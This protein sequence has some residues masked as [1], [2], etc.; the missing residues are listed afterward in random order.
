MIWGKQCKKIDNPIVSHNRLVRAAKQPINVLFP[1]R[2]DL[3]SN[4]IIILCDKEYDAFHTLIWKEQIFWKLMF[5]RMQNF[6][7]NKEDLWY[8][9]LKFLATTHVHHGQHR[10]LSDKSKTI[11]ETP[12]GPKHWYWS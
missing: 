8:T 1:Y 10:N 11:L 12:W 7:Y 9:F 3:S 5:E 6:V 2:L 4:D